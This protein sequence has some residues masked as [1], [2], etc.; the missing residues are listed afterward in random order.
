MTVVC[1]SIS[2]TH[3]LP[4]EKKVH[5]RLLFALERTKFS[6]LIDIANDNYPDH[7]SRVMNI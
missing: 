2:H 5:L 4:L 6:G 3:K 1:S 7:F